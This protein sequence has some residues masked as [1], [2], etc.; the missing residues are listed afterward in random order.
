[1]G[2]AGAGDLALLES[3]GGY[4][5]ARGL[6]RPWL[7]GVAYRQLGSLRRREYHQWSVSH[8]TSRQR[9]LGED[10]IARIEEQIDAARE[11][12]EVEHAMARLPERHREVLWLVGHEKLTTQEA[13][14]ALDINVGA[15]RV[16]LLRARRALREALHDPL[17][18]D[19]NFSQ[20]VQ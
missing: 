16:R 12:V 9:V 14:Q 17:P 1:M 10:A 4:N 5:P 6:F 20:E 13:A 15:F 7:I 19:P 8:V 2:E 3:G 18:P 11:S